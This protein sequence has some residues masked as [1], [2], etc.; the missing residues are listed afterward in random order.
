MRTNIMLDDDLVRE[1]LQCSGVKT[2]KEL[3]HMAL[4]EFVENRRRLILLDLEG[5][6]HPHGYSDPQVGMPFGGFVFSEVFNFRYLALVHPQDEN[7]V[8]VLELIGLIAVDGVVVVYSESQGR[9]ALEH[10]G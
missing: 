2:K 3:I 7:T 9:E 10:D 4:K 8:S 6:L 1:A 5:N